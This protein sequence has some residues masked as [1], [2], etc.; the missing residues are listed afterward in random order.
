MLASVT[1]D[2]H[3]SAAYEEYGDS[4]FKELLGAADM[5]DTE[6]DGFREPLIG[7]TGTAE[8]GNSSATSITDRRDS[9][10]ST[11]DQKGEPTTASVV[12]GTYELLEQILL[13]AD[14]GMILRLQCTSKTWDHVIN[15]SQALQVKLFFK[16]EVPHHDS[17][18]QEIRWNSLLLERNPHAQHYRAR[19]DLLQHDTEEYVWLAKIEPGPRPLA[20]IS[21]PQN[22]IKYQRGESWRRM[23]LVQGV[24]RLVNLGDFDRGMPTINAGVRM[25]QLERKILK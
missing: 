19:R 15:R 6:C 11:N 21:V 10:V 13:Q 5:S 23:L 4:F 14:N 7:K 3:Q 18:K 9:A 2:Q 24:Q 20:R 1:S 8:D 17:L 12:F 22:Y 16:A 25:G